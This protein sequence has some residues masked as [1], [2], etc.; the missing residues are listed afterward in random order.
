MLQG[1]NAADLSV[2]QPA[3]FDREVAPSYCAASHCKV[4]ADEVIE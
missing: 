1:V 3:R 4:A 2:V